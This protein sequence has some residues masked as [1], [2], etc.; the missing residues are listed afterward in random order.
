[1]V[2]VT[3]GGG[4]GDTG[5]QQHPHD[6]AAKDTGFALILHLHRHHHHRRRRRRPKIEADQLI[7]S[8]FTIRPRSGAI[9]VFVGLK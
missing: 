3:D 1:V 2:S 6:D 5:E 7:H 8:L 9:L 4:E